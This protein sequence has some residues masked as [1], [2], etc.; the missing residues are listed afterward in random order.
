MQKC[1]VYKTKDYVMIKGMSLCTLL[2]PTVG[3]T[4]IH[5]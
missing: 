3:L 2:Q 4:A 1:S 5:P